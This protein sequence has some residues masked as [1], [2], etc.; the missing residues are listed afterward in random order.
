MQAIDF[1]SSFTTLHI[2]DTNFK[3]R[4]LFKKVSFDQVFFHANLTTILPLT[5]L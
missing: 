3:V 2:H 5:K 4:H 1:I